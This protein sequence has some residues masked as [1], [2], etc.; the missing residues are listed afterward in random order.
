MWYSPEHLVAWSSLL[1]LTPATLALDAVPPP[2][3]SAIC[4]PP[5]L[6][7]PASIALEDGL[8][9]VVRWT[10][11]YSPTFRQQCRVL[12]STPGL[13]ATVRVTMRRPGSSDRARAIV[14]P[15]ASGGFAADIEIR[16]ASEI[17][18]L[19]AHEFEHLIE[20]LD[21]IDLG[22]LAQ[23]GQ[24]RRLED[25]AFETRR[26]IAAGQRVAGEVLDNAPDRVRRAGAAV[27]H[28]LKQ[29][30]RGSR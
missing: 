15:K 2:T 10:L 9:P 20:Q 16:N 5:A 28:A 21:G 7:L 23:R 30:V 29:T 25:G 3:P 24:A 13:T 17:P 26:A 4:D 14:R 12:A 27:W 6:M 8:Q 18:E 11:E 22:V 19:L 1:L